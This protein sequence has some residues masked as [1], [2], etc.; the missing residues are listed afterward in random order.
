MYQMSVVADDIDMSI[1]HVIRG[2]DHISNTPKQVLL[3]RALGRNASDFCPRAADSGAGQVRV[4]PSA[5]VR[6]M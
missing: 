4:S 3:Y 5:T 6:Q 2:A 1:T